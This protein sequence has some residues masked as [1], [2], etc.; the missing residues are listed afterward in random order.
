MA[1]QQ[2]VKL[3][4]DRVLT[5]YPSSDTLSRE[6]LAALAKYPTLS[7]KTDAYSES[8][9]VSMT[10]QEPE[11][12]TFPPLQRT[13]Q[14]RLTFSSNCMERYPSHTGLRPTI[15]PSSSGFLW[16]TLVDLQ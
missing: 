5:P 2:V 11:I 13:T 14:G 9:G 12:L 8:Q 10:F 3:W 6:A 16:N 15:F 1:Q 4:L 7:I